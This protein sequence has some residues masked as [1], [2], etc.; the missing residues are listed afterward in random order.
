MMEGMSRDDWS[1][2]QDEVTRPVNLVLDSDLE[3]LRRMTGE[4]RSALWGQI[5]QNQT[6]FEDEFAT[7]LPRDIMMNTRSKFAFAKLLLA[8]ADHGNDEQAAPAAGF[9][10][11]ELALVENF[12]KFNVFDVLSTDEI[13]DRIFRRGD[14]YDLVRT[15]YEGQFADLDRLLDDPDIER[16]IK[17]A[18]K[19]RYNKRLEK[20]VEGVQTYVG[21]YGPIIVV[22]Q[23]EQKVWDDI[24]KSEEQRKQIAD[25]L[26][27][28]MADVASRL[29]SLDQVESEGDRFTD[30]LR[31]IE[32][33]MLDG[34]DPGSLDALQSEKDRLVESYLGFEK[35][36]EGLIQAAQEKQRELEAREAELEKARGEYEQLTQEDKQRLVEGELK[37]I[38]ALKSELDS[39][40]RGLEEEK[41]SLQIKREELGD[42]L[43][44]IT[45]AMEGKSLRFMAKEDATLSEL[46]T[47][48]RFD[49][50]MQ[51]LPLKVRSPI[52]GKTYEIKSWKRGSHVKLAE[53][54]A[55]DVPSNLR[56]RYA[57]EERKHGVFGEKIE[58]VVIEAISL[59]HLR[60]YEEYGFDTRR[61]NLSEF[62]GLITEVIDSAEVGRYFHV[63]GIASPTGWDER[64]KEAIASTEFARNYVSRYVS[65]CLVD[66]VTGEM[67]LNPADE[68]ISQ[69]AD[70]FRPEFDRERVAKVISHIQKRLS[71]KDY[72]VFQDMV[73]ETGEER[74]F[75]NKAFHEMAEAKKARMRLIKDVGLVLEVLR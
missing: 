36:I 20:I 43:R 52:D 9:N 56:S 39:E 67:L 8:A 6:V 33:A 54:T 3:H 31:E 60:E 51:T 63:I 53:S 50:K 49:T 10:S 58:K 22:N 47:I 30:R 38:E 18:F 65:I 46:N 29:G 14:V 55:P 59:N 48:A 1:R 74:T 26:R 11:T 64:V 7:R 19:V 13:V 69:F 75:I 27:K 73:E 32:K 17:S 44:Q 5:Q 37:E 35:D 16:D 28:R 72:V 24:R 71:E 25:T 57:I 70:Y 68:R 41:S 40:A 34:N 12:E 15:F 45:D 42:R 21:K 2:F 62:L 23:I 66:S 4:K 61:A